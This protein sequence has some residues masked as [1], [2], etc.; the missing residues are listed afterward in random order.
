MPVSVVP[1]GTCSS[2][3]VPIQ[4][5]WSKPA[6]LSTSNWM[7]S[8]SA[9]ASW[10]T[11]LPASSLKCRSAVACSLMTRGASA[12]P[13]VMG[14]GLATVPSAG[15]GVAA[16][17]EPPMT[18]LGLRQQAGGGVAPGFGLPVRVAPAAHDP[19]LD[20]GAPVPCDTGA[21][22]NV[23]SELAVIQAMSSSTWR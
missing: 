10:V 18:P 11:M 5:L 3:G 1:L 15:G 12:V 16:G 9:T 14:S 23:T 21:Y 2:S 4:K 8:P 13:P 17:A 19:G 22:S 6:V 20:L 7:V